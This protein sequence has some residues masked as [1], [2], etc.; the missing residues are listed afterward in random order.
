MALRNRLIDAGAM[1]ASMAGDALL[2]AGESL[3]KAR[4][5]DDGSSPDEGQERTPGGKRADSAG[6]APIPTEEA[7]K[8]PESLFWDPYSIVEQLGY[9]ERPSSITYGTL[10][11][12]AWKIPIVTAVIQTRINQLAAFTAPQ[13]NRYD[14]G[15]RIKLR[16]SEKEPTK[17]DKN[18]MTQMET[19]I[20][21]TGV[22][23]SPRARDSFETFIRKL[24]WDSMV[25]DQ[26]AFEVV[27]NRKGQPAAW[28]AVDA[29]TIRLADSA[30]TYLKASTQDQSRYVQIYDA[31]VINEYTAEELAFGVRNPRTDLRLGGYGTSELEMLLTTVTSLLYALEYNKKAF[32]Q[33]SVHKGVLNF[34][35]AIPEKQLRAFR[36]HWYQMLSGVENAWRTPITNA[37]ELQWISMHSNNRDMEYN[38]YVDF[39]IKITCSMFQMDPVEV[40]FKYGNTGQSGGLNEGNN[41]EKV[42]ESK[43]RGLRP[44]LRFFAGLIN[45]HIIWP[46][47]ENYEFAF[48]GLDALTR[49]DLAKLNG[50]RVKTTWTVNELRAEEDKPP[51]PPEQGDIILDPTWAQLYQAAQAPAP[52][53]GGVPGQDGGQ[54][55]GGQDGAD[56]GDFESEF[57]RQFGGDKG[58]KGDENKQDQGKPDTGKAGAPAKPGFPA[59]RNGGQK[60]P[61]FGKSMGYRPVVVDLEL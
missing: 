31:M 17:Q 27:P 42:T 48:M 16:E 18:W 50:Q 46:I 43:E 28:Y 24:A 40:N 1:L 52:A 32:S 22:T 29:S 11:A 13:R 58:D 7:K 55:G 4:A 12:I 59:Q 33:G 15:F 36:R 38:A 21:R 39:L 54:P 23:D 10:R 41:R 9:K 37:D 6:N 25:F 14:M 19:L 47:N 20:T 2:S 53:E 34:K 60:A 26:C 56:D 30:T 61:P 51:L 49:D 57:M 35:G 3:L 5:G 45:Q 44:L 8:D